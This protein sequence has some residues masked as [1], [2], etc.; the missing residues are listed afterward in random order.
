MHKHEQIPKK[1]NLNYSTRAGARH[2]QTT[3][4]KMGPSGPT[5]NQ[6]M[7]NVSAC[8]FKTLLGLEKLVHTLFAG[9][10]MRQQFVR[11]GFVLVAKIRMQM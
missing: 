1:I 6:R 2:A 4:D 10:S 8:V 3:S 9:K 7:V 11:R 5:D